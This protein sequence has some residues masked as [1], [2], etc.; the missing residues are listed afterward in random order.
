VSEAIWSVYSIGFVV[1][2]FPPAK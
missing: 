1:C 2:V